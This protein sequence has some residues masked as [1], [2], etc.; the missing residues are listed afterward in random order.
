MSNTAAND[1]AESNVMCV[2]GGQARG[3]QLAAGG[4]Q[5]CRNSGVLSND[6]IMAMP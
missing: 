6:L 3:Q 5:R 4:G 2:A 1:F